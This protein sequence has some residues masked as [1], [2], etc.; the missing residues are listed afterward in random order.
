MKTLLLVGAFALASSAAFANIAVSYSIDGGAATNCATSAGNILADCGTFT[1]GPFQVNSLA[2]SSNSPGTPTL[3]DV[4]SATTSLTNIS[5]LT[6]TIEFFIFADGFNVPTSGNL[7][8]S[9][10]GTVV[11]GSAA[12]LV[13]YTSCLS[14]TAGSV[15]PGGSIVAG[16]G[17]PS[18]TT[19]GGYSDSKTTAVGSIS[20]P[21]TVSEDLK[22]TLGA[23]SSL[24]FS[25]STFTSA[26]PEP[27]TFSLMGAGLLGLGL[28]RKR[29]S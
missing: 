27:M 24:N 4:F 28:L 14:T 16:P 9:L 20:T 7:I 19:P 25:A 1:N 26:V 18:I 8:S 23:G 15:C 12:N 13:S 2:A 22:F 10:G 11:S 6:H 21:Y 29:L 5:G 3:S 17:T